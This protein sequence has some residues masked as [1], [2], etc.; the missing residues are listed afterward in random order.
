MLYQLVHHDGIKSEVVETSPDLP[1]IASRDGWYA[2]AIE[3]KVL[4]EGRSW[5]VIDQNHPM[6][7]VETS[8]DADADLYIKSAVSEP[9][10]GAGLTPEPVLGPHEPS[11]KQI[12]PLVGVDPSFSDLMTFQK[13]QWKAEREAQVAEREAIAILLRNRKQ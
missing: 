10:Q 7:F 6:F 2:Q 1:N 12:A 5:A 3:G 11:A 8:Q 4:P 9:R 13:E